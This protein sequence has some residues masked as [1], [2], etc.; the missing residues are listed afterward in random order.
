MFLHSNHRATALVAVCS[1]ALLVYGLIEA[2][3]RRSIAPARTIDG[4]LPE[5]RAARPTAE[6]IFHAF[7]GP[8]C[9]RVRTTTGLE[10]MPDPLSR[11]QQAIIDA[12]DITSVVPP[13]AKRHSQPGRRT[14]LDR[15]PAGR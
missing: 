11:A 5:R 8:G 3:K 4:L 1:I 2:E 6:N 14:G 12:L 7:A 15:A 13:K 10:A 9:Q